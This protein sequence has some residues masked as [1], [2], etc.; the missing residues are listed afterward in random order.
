M[1][2]VTG[3]SPREGAELGASRVPGARRADL[4]WAAGDRRP[5]PAHHTGSTARRQY[6][7]SDGPGRD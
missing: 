4:G 1:A 5:G 6:R 2:P 7:V 3:V